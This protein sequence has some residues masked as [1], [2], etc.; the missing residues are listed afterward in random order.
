VT[1]AASGCKK[2][3]GNN[4]NE[5]ADLKKVTRDLTEEQGPPPDLRRPRADLTDT[6][7]NDNEDLSEVA[8]GDDLASSDTDM[9]G[10]VVDTDMPTAGG[11][12]LATGGGGGDLTAGPSDMAQSACAQTATKQ[13]LFGTF[14]NRNFDTATG[15]ATLKLPLGFQQTG[16]VTLPDGF[17]N[18]LSS[19]SGFTR[20]TV[21]FYNK[22]T[23]DSYTSIR[24]TDIGGNDDYAVDFDIV[25]PA[26][27]YELRTTIEFTSDEGGVIV[28]SNRRDLVVC[29][30]SLAQTIDHTSLPLLA[31]RFVEIDGVNG[32]LG[33]KAL[34]DD[35][36]L[37]AR[38][39][40]ETVETGGNKLFVAMDYSDLTNGGSL[41]FD[42]L[43][44]PTTATSYTVKPFL[45]VAALTVPDPRD[46]DTNGWQ[47]LHRFADATVTMDVLASENEAAF[48]SDPALS[49]S[50]VSTVSGAV[51]DPS[52]HLARVFQNFNV[53]FDDH[54]RIQHTVVC[55]DSRGYLYTDAKGYSMPVRKGP[56]SLQ[57]FFSVRVPLAANSGTTPAFPESIDLDFPN[58][59]DFFALYTNPVAKTIVADLPNQDY[60]IP[61]SLPG[62]TQQTLT[63]VDNDDVPVQFA[64][65]VAESQTN[66]TGLL[67]FF[68]RG[69]AISDDLGEVELNLLRGTYF[70]TVDAL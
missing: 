21:S 24:N 4:N 31:R 2:D 59:N 34:E 29:G 1:A 69:A 20:G 22:L 7:P 3:S 65:V 55:T 53:G 46:I 14:L 16:T 26:G 50:D 18:G 17:I 12:D 43:P 70:I 60:A 68:G 13:V 6:N 37:A 40:V 63:V 8:T 25:V 45:A 67:D 48:A 57:G 42:N 66:L 28:S 49:P 52:A 35:S 32:R 9:T 47:Y 10:V 51:T 62:E 19:S 61:A 56:C 58:F 41:D 27:N 11:G 15:T 38:F 54:L 23:G 33:A 5:V 30:D 44:L 39:G 36:R 64:I